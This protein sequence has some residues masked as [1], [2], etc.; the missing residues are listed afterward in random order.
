MPADSLR[1]SLCE[2]AL[3]ELGKKDSAAAE[4]QLSL[5]T[6]PRR[7]DRVRSEI[8]KGLAERDPVAALTRV[9]EIAGEIGT[10]SRGIQLVSSVVGKAAAKDP[11][12]ALAAVQQLPEELR[13]VASQAAF[14]GR[15]ERGP[16]E[17]LEWAR[18]N[19]IDILSAKADITFGSGGGSWRAAMSAAF[20][21]D[22]EETLAWLR[23]QPVSRER[24]SMLAGGLFGGTLDQRLAILSELTP[25]GRAENIGSVI[26]GGWKSIDVNAAAKIVDS[27]PAGAERVAAVEGLVSLQLKSDTGSVEDLV[28]SYPPG[29]ERDAAACGAATALSETNREQALAV[30]AQINEATRRETAYLKIVNSWL[31]RDRPAAL[32]WISG[33]QV[34]EPDV[35]RALLRQI[36]ER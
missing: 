36:E 6:D 26:S 5:L 20:D 19:G 35:Q 32:A 18:E 8:I 2:E 16:K 24:D 23:E 1:A 22:R 29:L 11:E 33:T 28:A 21:I 31:Y 25:E 3:T 4:A 30:A 17:A 15:I 27:L 9:T 7:Q 34:F 12:A 14:V 10:G 13:P